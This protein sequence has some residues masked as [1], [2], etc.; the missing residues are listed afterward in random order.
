MSALIDAKRAI[1][2]AEPTWNW[3]AILTRAPLEAGLTFGQK[4]G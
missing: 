2:V 3:Q 1:I 4:E